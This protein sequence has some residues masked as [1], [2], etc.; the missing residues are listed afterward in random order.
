MIAGEPYIVCEFTSLVEL[1]N[2]LL[3]CT[4]LGCAYRVRDTST[5]NSDS[6]VTVLP[7]ISRAFPPKASSFGFYLFELQFR[8]SLLNW[9]MAMFAA[10][11]LR[12]DQ[13]TR[14]TAMKQE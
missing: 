13:T 1:T 14:R 12:Q 3:V 5:Y 10:F 4:V 9:P 11:S 7:I 6:Y 2:A 8:G